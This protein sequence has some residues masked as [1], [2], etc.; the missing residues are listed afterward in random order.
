MKR[1]ELFLCFM[2]NLCIVI[3]S[4]T[5]K[6]LW[7]RIRKPFTDFRRFIMKTARFSL[8][9]VPIEQKT[10]LNNILDKTNYKYSEEY[11]TLSER[12]AILNQQKNQMQSLLRSSKHRISGLLDYSNELDLKR[13]LLESEMSQ[14]DSQFKDANKFLDSE[15]EINT[16]SFNRL[17]HELELIFQKLNDSKSIVDTFRDK[18]SELEKINQNLNDSIADFDKKIQKIKEK[19]PKRPPEKIQEEISIINSNIPK[20]NKEIQLKE[21]AILQKELRKIRFETERAQLKRKEELLRN[22]IDDVIQNADLKINAIRACVFSKNDKRGDI[23]SSKIDKKNIIYSLTNRIEYQQNRDAE[24]TEKIN[25]TLLKV[26]LTKDNMIRKGKETNQAVRKLNEIQNTTEVILARRTKNESKKTH[27]L[28]N[29]RDEYRKVQKKIGSEQYII[30]QSVV[31]AKECKSNLNQIDLQIKNLD[32][33]STEL[34][35]ESKR[36]EILYEE[37]REKEIDNEKQINLGLIELD[38]L[39]KE[40][41]RQTMIYKEIMDD[42]L[43]LLSSNSS[44]I[45]VKYQVKPKEVFDNEKVES[46]SK[47]L[48]VSNNVKELKIKLKKI[49]QQIQQLKFECTKAQEQ[50]RITKKELLSKKSDIENMKYIQ[51]YMNHEKISYDDIEAKDK[52]I[53]LRMRKY[54]NDDLIRKIQLKHMSILDRKRKMQIQNDHLNEIIRTQHLKNY[55]NNVLLAV[56]NDLNRRN[57]LDYQKMIN[58]YHQINVSKI[59]GL[60]KL[61]EFYRRIKAERNIFTSF[62]KEASVNNILETWNDELE[63]LIV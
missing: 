52:L 30:S 42:R 25:Q 33:V 53:K 55:G 26:E 31:K 61:A 45:S 5:H 11:Q 37:N 2:F 13:K 24:L 60:D 23:E 27:E 47:A 16:E 18:L 40:I 14:L 19:A 50:R 58:S 56:C 36:V 59:V 51:E 41:G 3:W 1:R 54:D 43:E 39:Q 44:K 15:M 6:K 9:E 7:S 46:E 34:Q 32:D 48:I 49:F 38:N 17:Q 28:L 35:R 21:Q 4:D 12:N 10:S 62:V 29:I 57:Y 63:Q 8:K 22:E 20:A